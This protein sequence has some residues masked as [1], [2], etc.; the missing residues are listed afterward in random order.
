MNIFDRSTKVPEELFEKLGPTRDPYMLVGAS[1]LFT[2]LMYDAPF[3]YS[4]S[5]IVT[6]L[7]SKSFLSLEFSHEHSAPMFLCTM[8]LNYL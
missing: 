8:L 2:Y 4:Y 5:G 1:L 3:I 6:A 7:H